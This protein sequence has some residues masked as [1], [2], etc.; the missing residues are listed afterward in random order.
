MVRHLH[1]RSMVQPAAL[2]AAAVLACATMSCAWIA[3]AEYAPDAGVEPPPYIVP[4]SEDPAFESTLQY[5]VNDSPTFKV[6]VG[7]AD[8]N[9]ELQV[10][11]CL[12][13]GADAT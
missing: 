2:L 5:N 10:R 11:F 9:R 1:N 12:R 13:E 6:T 7:D 3:P 8:V 4:H